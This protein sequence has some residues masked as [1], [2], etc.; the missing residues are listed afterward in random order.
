MCSARSLLKRKHTLRS[1]VRYLVRAR[2]HCIEPLLHQ[3]RR[4]AVQLALGS[5]VLRIDATAPA[6]LGHARMNPTLLPLTWRG[7]GA[8]GARSPVV[9]I[10]PDGR[11]LAISPGVVVFGRIHAIANSPHE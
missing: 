2:L 8:Q 10:C 9:Y 1:Q 4:H 11:I 7:L 6:A 3:R 5:S